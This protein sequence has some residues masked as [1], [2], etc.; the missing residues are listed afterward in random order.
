MAEGYC[1]SY[2][3]PP[4]LGLVYAG[5]NIAVMSGNLIIA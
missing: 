1:C 2:R 5:V 3:R 4:S